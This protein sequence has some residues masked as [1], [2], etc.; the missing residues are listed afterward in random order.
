[1]RASGRETGAVG[2]TLCA[3][4]AVVWGPVWAQPDAVCLCL[5]CLQA[6]LLRVPASRGQKA[7]ASTLP[8]PPSLLES[9]I[10][11]TLPEA[12]GLPLHT[13]AVITEETLSMF[14]EFISSQTVRKN[15]YPPDNN[16]ESD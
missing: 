3:P 12:L 15:Y 2:G 14:R 8:W 6:G 7:N 11:A 10:L 9:S 13:G 4:L 16:I 5:H 1:M